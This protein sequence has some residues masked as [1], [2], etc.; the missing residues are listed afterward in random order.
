M[1][2]FVIWPELVKDGK[3]TANLAT[4]ADYLMHNATVFEVVT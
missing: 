4:A 1:V 2:S 3:S